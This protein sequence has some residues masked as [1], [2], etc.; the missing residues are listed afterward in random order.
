MKQILFYCSFLSIFILSCSPSWVMKSY[1]RQTQKVHKER[2]HTSYAGLVMPYTKFTGTYGEYHNTVS[3]NVSYPGK[4]GFGAILG[5][6]GK[7]IG[8]ELS[9][10][11]SASDITFTDPSSHPSEHKGKAYWSQL[12]TDLRLSLTGDSPIRPYL[13]TGLGFLWLRPD[14]KEFF[15]LTP[16]WNG[17]IDGICLNLGGGIQVRLTKAISMSGIV[18]YQPFGFS[19]LVGYPNLSTIIYNMQGKELKYQVSIQVH[20]KN[21]TAVNEKPGI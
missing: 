20:F 6:S 7:V 18:V 9:Y 2:W 12:N 8:G 13:I 5:A 16:L 11:R 19:D 10:M 14:N 15:E 4:I 17:I 1:A 3:G 21:H